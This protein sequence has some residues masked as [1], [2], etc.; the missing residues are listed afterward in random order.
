LYGHPFE[1][2]DA[3]KNNQDIEDFYSGKMTIEVSMD[4]LR[5]NYIDWVFTG[6]REAESGSPKILD[7]QVPEKLFGEVSLYRVERIVNHD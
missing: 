7:G 4:F 6:P 5:S 3:E 1:S 2:I